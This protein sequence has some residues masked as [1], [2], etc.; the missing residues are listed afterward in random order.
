MY[1]FLL[2]YGVPFA[3]SSEKRLFDC[4]IW[5]NVSLTIGIFG[6]EYLWK[7]QNPMIWRRWVL[8]PPRPNCLGSSLG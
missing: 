4:P 7:A 5:Y 6:V 3:T 1:E 8:L 2:F